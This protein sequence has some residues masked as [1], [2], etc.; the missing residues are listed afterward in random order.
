MLN[1]ED[2]LS[3][4]RCFKTDEGNEILYRFVRSKANPW[5][6][7]VVVEQIVIKNKEEIFL[8]ELNGYRI[9]GVKNIQNEP[10]FK[11]EGK[12]KPS[13]DDKFYNSDIMIR[14]RM[15]S[16]VELASISLNNIQCNIYLDLELDYPEKNYY[17]TMEKLSTEFQENNYVKKVEIKNGN[18]HTSL[19]MITEPNYMFDYT[20]AYEKDPYK[21][22]LNSTKVEIKNEIINDSKVKLTYFQEGKNY[23]MTVIG[24]E[25]LNTE[26]VE[27]VL[28]NDFIGS[29]YKCISTF[30][31]PLFQKCDNVKV[32]CLAHSTCSDFYGLDNLS[33]IKLYIDS[34]EPTI[35]DPLKRFIESHE[36]SLAKYLDNCI[37]SNDKTILEKIIFNNRMIKI[38]SLCYSDASCFI[39]KVPNTVTEVAP[40]A[41]FDELKCVEKYDRYEKR[42]RYEYNQNVAIYLY[43]DKNTIKKI[44]DPFNIRKIGLGYNPTRLLR[45]FY[46]YNWRMVE[47]MI[48]I[49]DYSILNNG[50]PYCKRARIISFGEN[51]EYISPLQIF[52]YNKYIKFKVNKKNKNYY[53]DG[54]KIYRLKD[55]VEVV[56]DNDVAFF[57]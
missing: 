26:N 35:I 20:V 32:L 12:F 8:E 42:I 46:L 18:R 38:T 6:P 24:V 30:E 57:K 51:V 11:I 23:V 29:G 40:N 21:L 19:H 54:K 37:L 44:S 49:G 34:G 10:F 48:Y 15:I 53:S 9:L 22:D 27:L 36:D 56:F 39:C 50:E 55:D 47:K 7:L 45:S 2:I 41:F 1:M 13:K 28:Y 25:P 4:Q 16:L 33:E 17:S 52:E 3:K 5:L 31:K 14:V 43:Q